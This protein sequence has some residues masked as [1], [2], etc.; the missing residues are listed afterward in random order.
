MRIAAMSMVLVL[1]AGMFTMTG[2]LAKDEVYR[3]VDENGVVHFGDQPDAAANAEV[4]EIK[5][6][7]ATSGQAPAAATTGAGSNADGAEPSYAQRLREERAAKRKEAAEQRKTVDGNC[8][9]S[10]EV[11]AQL[12]PSPRVNVTHEDGSVTRMDDDERLRVLNEAKAFIAENC[13]N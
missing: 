7:P 4:I 2:A 6:S 8:K 5:E 3:W 10:R 11:V 13:E 1:G 9:R 12:E